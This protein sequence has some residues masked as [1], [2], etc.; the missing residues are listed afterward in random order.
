VGGL[1]HL[2]HVHNTAVYFKYN[3]SRVR[4]RVRVLYSII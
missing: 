1:D 3:I 2:S 4:V